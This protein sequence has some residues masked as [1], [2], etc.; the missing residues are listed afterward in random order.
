MINRVHYRLIPFMCL[1]LVGFVSCGPG[2]SGSGIETG[3]F[4]SVSEFLNLND[5]FFLTQSDAGG[6]NGA[7]LDRPA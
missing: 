1:I 6:V 5:S 2:L 7:T 4:R 3:V